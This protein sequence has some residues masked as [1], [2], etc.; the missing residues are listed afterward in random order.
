MTLAISQPRLF[1]Y[2][3]YSVPLNLIDHLAAYGSF[4]CMKREPEQSA[5]GS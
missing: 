3:G 5:S 1:P 2:C 4:P